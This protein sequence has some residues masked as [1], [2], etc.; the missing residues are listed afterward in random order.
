M[1]ETAQKTTTAASPIR[2]AMPT[3]T[4][5]RDGS[6]SGIWRQAAIA[7]IVTTIAVTRL[8]LLTG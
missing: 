5:N 8:C 3:P 6:W 2:R 7:T 4:S 1:R